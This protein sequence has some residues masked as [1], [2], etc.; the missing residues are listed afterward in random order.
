MA[1]IYLLGERDVRILQDAVKLINNRPR[2]EIMRPPVFSDTPYL[3]TNG[4][5]GTYVARTPSTGI[6]A[7]KYIAT[8]TAPPT[9]VNGAECR[10]FQVDFINGTLRPAQE[11]K[12]N[13][14]NLSTQKIPGDAWVVVM[15]DNYGDYI[16]VMVAKSEPNQSSG[17]GEC[18]LTTMGSYDCVQVNTYT[19]FGGK[20]EY[21]LEY[22]GGGHWGNSLAYSY[23]GGSGIFDFYYD[24]GRMILK[25]D[26]MELAS[27]GDG[28]YSGGWI[29]GHGTPI[30]NGGTSCDEDAFT[31]CVE[32]SCCAIEG[33][34]GPGW[35]CVEDSGPDDCVP[36]ELLDEDK[37][38]DDIVICSGPYAS[39][40][41]ALLFCPTGATPIM[42]RSCDDAFANPISAAT[43]YS[44][45]DPVLGGYIFFPAT[46]GSTV[47]LTVTAVTGSVRI[48]R[49]VVGAVAP[50]GFIIFAS[51]GMSVDC[52]D[53]VVGGSDSGFLFYFG[54]NDGGGSPPYTITFSIASGACPP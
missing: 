43:S 39:E 22:A 29:T 6:P 15:Q 41:A 35:Y 19:T 49:A 11:L 3:D 42:L 44:V 54:A 28:C 20:V 26:D 32:C 12:P 47:S 13:V 36:L 25:L 40:A 14:Y 10:V 17:A 5:P 45:N 52:F 31:V 21:Y 38:D 8:G 9:D 30:T 2:N 48:T 34:I 50:C 7:I 53:F 51:L 18:Q 46:G 24:D 1:E 23:P 33:Y 37:C 16:A 4:R 27:C